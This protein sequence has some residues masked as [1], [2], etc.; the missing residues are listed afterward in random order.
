MLWTKFQPD[1]QTDR[2]NYYIPSDIF[3]S[4]DN[5]APLTVVYTSIEVERGNPTKLHHPAP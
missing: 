4:G 5:K 2:T 3:F 1:G